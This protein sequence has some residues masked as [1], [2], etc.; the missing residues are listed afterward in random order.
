V[1]FCGDF[2]GALVLAEEAEEETSL[3]DK[4]ELLK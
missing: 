1:S 3:Q 2:W 4:K